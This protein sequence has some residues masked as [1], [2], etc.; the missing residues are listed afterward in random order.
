MILHSII[1]HVRRLCIAALCAAAFAAASCSSTKYVPDDQFLLDDMHIGGNLHDV[2]PSDFQDY[3][4]QQ[5]N[6]RILGFWRA[7]LGVYNLSRP[8]NRWFS[9]WLRRT[10]EAP[11]IY[12]STL[13]VRTRDQLL[14]YMNNRG[15]FDAQVRDSV[16]I[17]GERKCEVFY[18]INAGEPYR[19]NRV[20]YQISDSLIHPLVVG[21]AGNSL[22]REGDI[23]DVQKHD[24]ERIRIAR[25]LN[26]AGYY[27]FGKDYI[28]FLAD[29]SRAHHTVTDSLVLLNSITANVGDQSQQHRRAIVDDVWVVVNRTGQNAIDIESGDYDV[30][31]AR[32]LTLL[33][34]G[35]LP[36]NARLFEQSCFV[37][38]GEIYNVVDA[39]QTQ[40]RFRALRIFSDFNIRFVEHA[41]SLRTADN[42]QHL[43]CIITTTIARQQSYSASLEGTNSSGNFGVAASL[44]YRHANIF[45]K[46]EVLDVKGRIA[47]QK[48]TARD[49]KDGFYTLETGLEASVTIPKFIVPF[50]TTNTFSRQHNP[51]T[52]FL[53]AYDYQRRPDFTKQVVT[54]RMA[55]SWLGRNQFVRHSLTPIEVNMVSIPA[56]SNEFK[57][58]VDKTYL[59]YSYTNHLIFSANYTYLFNQQTLS[60]RLGN[61]WYARLSA[62]TAGNFLSLLAQ[63]K[64]NADEAVELFGIE[65]SQYV[66][67]EAEL[68]YQMS[69]LWSNHFVYRLLV[70]VGIPYGNSKAL[71]FEK[72]FFVGGANSIRAWA[73][74]SL[75]PGSQLSDSEIRYNNQTSDIRIEANMEYRF[76]LISLLDGALFADAGNIWALPREGNAPEAR[77]GKEFYKQIALGAG[78]GL[79]LNFGYFVV[80]LDGAV[81]LHDPAAAAGSRWVIGQK[82]FQ[83]SDIN[84][85]FAIGYPF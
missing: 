62:E 82:S 48:Q 73:V 74:R 24:D 26:E 49:S 71:P 12:D 79:R 84:Y 80:R 39:E 27:S 37:R 81:K 16:I 45:N 57:N 41:D 47:S 9:N 19:I 11:V 77:F 64:K 38:A 55:Y 32:G 33:H 76:K 46:A 40:A 5:P 60:E 6:S 63:K 31:P 21:D 44:G 65:Y 13:T 2:S 14:L 3:I 51:T 8:R 53:T 70:G 59:R 72:R 75:G 68:R 43:R 29:S 17:T 34:R 25:R 69:D 36:I 85:N 83:L 54:M 18:N 10:G 30:S 67:A 20:G 66:R 22:V 15:Y 1:R 78:L 28:Y 42:F 23:F 35:R 50:A 56:I 58:Y 52:R 7:R 4:R 61:A